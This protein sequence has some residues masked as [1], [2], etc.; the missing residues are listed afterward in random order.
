V[1][2]NIEQFLAWPY[3]TGII[4]AVKTGVPD[5]LPPGFLTGTMKVEGDSGRYTEYSG[6]RTVSKRTEYG[7]PS[8]NRALSAISERDVKLYHSKENIVLNPLLYQR[9]RRY[10]EPAQQK[11]GQEEVERQLKQFRAVFD[12][13]R[14]SMVYSMLATGQISWDSDRDLLPSSSGAQV[15]VDF[16][17]SANHQNQLN[18]IIGASWAT[19]STDII[20][21]IIAI[22]KQSVQDTGYQIECAF[23]GQNVSEYIASNDVAQAFM[24]RNSSFNDRFLNSGLIPDGFG[25]IKKWFPVFDAFYVDGDGTTREWFGGDTVVFTP[26]PS[27]GWYEMLEGSYLV[28]KS[29][30]PSTA[31]APFANV[32]QVYGM[33]SYATLENDP[34]TAKII[35]GDTCLPV[36]KVD[37]NFIADVT[38]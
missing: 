32:D 7:S 38:P 12:N 24:A 21:D 33:F 13:T 26:D 28:P 9:M 16:G 29:F 20:G 34:L 17:V 8:V 25:G 22:R 27:A 31:Q 10:S 3:L 37:C 36:Q 23:Y 30:G 15:T 35:Y 2:F 19:N 11:M 14:L 6:T 18:G 5:V 1:A 4:E